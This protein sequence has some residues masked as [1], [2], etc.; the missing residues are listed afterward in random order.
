MPGS[1]STVQLKGAQGSCLSGPQV[2]PRGTRAAGG[3]VSGGPV[4]PGGLPEA[5][6]VALPGSGN[7]SRSTAEAAAVLGTPPQR[8]RLREAEAL[9]EGWGQVRSAERPRDVHSVPLFTTRLCVDCPL[10]SRRAHALGPGAALDSSRP[11][12]WQ[13]AGVDQSPVTHVLSF[14]GG[15]LAVKTGKI[16]GAGAGL[17]VPPGVW[18]GRQTL[19]GGQNPPASRSVPQSC[20]VTGRSELRDAPVSG[21]A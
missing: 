6:R 8:P 9:G 19:G 11:F 4:L 12:T 21:D 17:G 14:P 15:P 3:R 7:S 18:P 20:S 2:P 13:P 16:R 5:P 1:D 10:P